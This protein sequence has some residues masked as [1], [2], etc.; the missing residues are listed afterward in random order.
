M[1]TEIDRQLQQ[2]VAP[3]YGGISQEMW[4][5]AP[6]AIRNRERRVIELI[7]RTGKAP[8]ILRRK[9]MIFLPKAA[10][11][12]PTLDNT[13]GLPPWRPIT[14]QSALASRL[15]LVV[16]RYV[17]PGIPISKMQH[18]FQRDRT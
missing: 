12:D 5:A 10:T 6:A 1:Q 4:I 3:G 7:L 8:P 18:G 16:K 15:F 11:V 14:V 17:E 2:H 9:Q 13:K